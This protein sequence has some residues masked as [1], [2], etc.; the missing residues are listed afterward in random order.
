MAIV[1]NHWAYVTAGQD[2]TD[3]VTIA[4]DTTGWTAT[5]TVRAVQGGTA[6]ITKTTSSG[7]TNTP[8][9]TAVASTMVIALDDTDL[10]LTPGAYYCQLWRTNAG[11]E[12]PIFDV[13][14]LYVAAANDSAYPTLTNLSEY[15]VHALYNATPPDNLAAQLTQMLAGAEEIIRDLCGRQ[16][17]RGTYTE[18]PDSPGRDYF[19]LRETPVSTTGLTL[20]LD[21][22]AMAGQ[23]A[24]DFAAATLLTAG[25]DYWLDLSRRTTAGESKT[26]RVYRRGALWPARLTRPV[27]RLAARREPWPG[28]LKVSY[29]GGYPLVPMSLKQAVWDL[30][31]IGAEAA[32]QGRLPVSESGEG[33]SVSRGEMEKEA[34]RLNSVQAVVHKYA[35]AAAFVA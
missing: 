11:A 4:A 15:C 28:V 18:Y 31:T 33:Y 8:D 19:D 2:A 12:Y 23:G 21:T 24:D 1:Q 20:Y 26:G 9:G 35:R 16:F 3:T 17:T 22:G 5:F 7:I 29:T 32:A 30:A 6:L 27:G 14:T 13:G 25:T 34:Q 10:D